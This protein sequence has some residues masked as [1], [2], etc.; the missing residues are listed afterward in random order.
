VLAS[1]EL[2]QKI[3]HVALPPDVWVWFV[4]DSIVASVWRKQVLDWRRNVE[5][6]S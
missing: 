3:P 4:C 5:P 2:T 1:G 6:A